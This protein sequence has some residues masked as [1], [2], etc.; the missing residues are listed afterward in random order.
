MSASRERAEVV[1]ILRLALITYITT[2]APQCQL[3]H[4]P[5]NDIT[6]ATVPLSP[7][8]TEPHL[9]HPFAECEIALA[10]SEA[11]KDLVCVD[12]KVQIQNLTHCLQE[13]LLLHA[14]GQEVQVGSA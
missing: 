4:L 8:P 1:G 10:C 11:L 3:H 5:I 7:F 2:V 13:V 9:A 6:V 12:V 14:S